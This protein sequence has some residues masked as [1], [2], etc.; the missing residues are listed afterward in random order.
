MLDGL[1]PAFGFGFV[2]GV[3]P[4][5]LQTFLLLQTL[6]RG[7]RGGMWILPAPLVSDGPIIAVCLLA[8]SRAGPGLLRGLSL[9]GGLFLVYL[10]R[11]GWL[12]LTRKEAAKPDGGGD[13]AIDR[14]VR[15]ITARHS[16]LALLGRAA[17]INALGPGPWIFWG[18]V[19]GPV[20]VRQWH[21][22]AASGLAF[23]AAFYGTLVAI[24]T[25]QLLL[26]SFARR[27]GPKIARAGTWLGLGLL[28]VFAALLI[29]FGIGAIDR[30][31]I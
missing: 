27:L 8:L 15:S 3:M 11:E 17:L 31:G 19:M 5:P 30:Y 29:L 6:Q 1:A 2:A 14:R 20:L 4:G 23:L 28:A 18:T 13:H 16:G 25:A 10:A 21:A 26:F 12:S 24:L 7:A 22:S 9:A